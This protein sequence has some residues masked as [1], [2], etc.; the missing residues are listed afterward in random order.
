LIRGTTTA[1]STSDGTRSIACSADSK[2]SAES[3]PDSRSSMS[4]SWASS[5]LL[6]SLTGFGCV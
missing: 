5:V 2:D 1:N 3:S 4:C 6:W